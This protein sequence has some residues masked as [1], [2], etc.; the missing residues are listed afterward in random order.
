[1]CDTTVGVIA[2]DGLRV[3]RISDRDGIDAETAARRA[4]FQQ[5]ADFYKSNC[6]FIIENNGNV[7]ELEEKFASL[8]NKI[9]SENFNA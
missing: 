7:S 6:I 1:M 5:N 8:I 9:G 4:S 3:K 2:D